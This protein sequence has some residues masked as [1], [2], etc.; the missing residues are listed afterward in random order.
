MFSITFAIKAE[1]GTTDL[2][3]KYPVGSG[4]LK[5]KV[6]AASDTRITGVS[7]QIAGSAPV[8]LELTDDS[9]YEL[10]EPAFAAEG[11]LSFIVTAVSTLGADVKLKTIRYST[12]IGTTGF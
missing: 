2:E 4:A 12:A 9:I 5:F 6:N 3:A 1:D 7:Y 8:E 10:P 11:N